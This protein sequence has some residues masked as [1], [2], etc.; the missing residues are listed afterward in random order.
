MNLPY[1]KDNFYNVII[2]NRIQIAQFIHDMCFH[3]NVNQSYLKH[4][5]VNGP[6]N[7]QG[8]QYSDSFRWHGAITP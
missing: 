5:E 1:Y 6:G 7:T 2:L 8:K 3:Y 4:L